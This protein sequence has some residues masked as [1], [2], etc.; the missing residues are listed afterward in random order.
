MIR[1]K[2]FWPMPAP[3]TNYCIDLRDSSPLARVS[4]FLSRAFVSH[5]RMITFPCSLRCHRTSLHG[6]ILGFFGAVMDDSDGAVAHFF[7]LDKSLSAS[8]LYHLIS[9]RV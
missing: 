1:S 3:R 7:V 4:N 8:V 2:I 6:R 5:K 9:K